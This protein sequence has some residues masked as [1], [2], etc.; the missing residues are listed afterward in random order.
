MGSDSWKGS[1]ASEFFCMISYGSSSA[2]HS[3]DQGGVF[4]K[5]SLGNID[6]CLLGGK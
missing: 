5:I 2:V 4:E 1:R 6:R 3:I